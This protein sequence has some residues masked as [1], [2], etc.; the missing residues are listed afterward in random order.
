VRH[1]CLT[2]VLLAGAG[3]CATAGSAGDDDDDDAIDAGP[4]PDAGDDPSSA[5]VLYLADRTQSPITTRVAAGLRAIA[6]IDERDG[7]HFAKLGDSI[8]VSD[9]FFHCFAAGKPPSM[10][11]EL[12]ATRAAF[13]PIGLETETSF[14]RESLAAGV[15]WSLDDLTTGAPS[16][17]D[18]ELG[19]LTPRYAIVMFGT[20]D[21]EGRDADD[22]GDRLLGLVDELIAQGTVPILSTIPPRDF[23]ANDDMV[24]VLNGVIRGVA[25]GRQIPLVDYWR[26]LIKL[27]DYGLGEDGLHPSTFEGGCNFTETGLAAGYNVRNLVTLT[28]L[29]RTRQVVAEAEPFFDPTAPTLA[30][31]GSPADPYE[32][33]QLPFADVRDSADG[34]SDAID[35]YACAPDTDESGREHVYRIEVPGATTLRINVVDR[36]DTDV[37]VHL[38]S[39]SPT[40]AACLARG[41]EELTQA[42]A[43]GTYYVVV[44]TF[45]ADST[46]FAGEFVVSIVT[47]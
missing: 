16:P 10:P 32:V 34:P 11:N 19:A 12:E 22:F 8:T 43:A 27:G 18:Q 17:L 3:G 1:A 44:D 38:L 33:P 31:A 39:G 2:A 14:D 13:P 42:V 20:N 46:E 41:H 37:D 24:Q 9:Q 25:Q 4:E 5:P 45:V 15:G 30:G 47:Q 6:A 35:N 23:N 26:E 29:D 21:A 40:G 28:A 7:G 36:E